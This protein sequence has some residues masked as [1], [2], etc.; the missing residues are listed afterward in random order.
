M[1]TVVRRGCGSH[2]FKITEAVVVFKVDIGLC[3]TISGIR[4]WGD[5]VCSAAV[6][7][8][9]FG[10]VSLLL[11]SETKTQQFLRLLFDVCTILCYYC[12]GLFLFRVSRVWY[13]SCLTQLMLGVVQF[14]IIID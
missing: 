2:R 7:S 14:V 4:G 3:T 9:Q 6:V 5:S 12:F 1:V 11:Q 13:Y 10:V 8:R